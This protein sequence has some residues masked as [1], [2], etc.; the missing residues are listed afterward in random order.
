M[1]ID[2]KNLLV[3]S[4]T[5]GVD[6]LVDR[7]LSTEDNIEKSLYA[8]ALAL[9]DRPLKKMYVESC[10]LASSDAE[11]I[12]TILELSP[13]VV[14]MYAAMFYD[15]VNLD[16]LSK[17]ELL[18]VEDQQER[19]LKLWALNQGLDFLAWRLGKAVQINPIEGLKDLFSTSMYKAKEAMFSGN[20]T[21]AS[22]EAVK[23]TK[24]SM[25]LARL[26]KAYTMDGDQARKDIELALSEVVPE[27]PGF[28]TLN[29]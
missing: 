12:G 7:I 8:Q 20:E 27:F 21:E 17:M 11:K 1:S 13:E 14:A 23:W 4:K 5:L 10:L 16:K 19:L 18:Q 28:D 24:M 15:T 22:K 6:P 26:L 9:R 29:Q 25:D 3:L 2:A